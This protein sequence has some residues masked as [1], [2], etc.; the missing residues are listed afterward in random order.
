M[1]KPNDPTD[2][3]RSARVAVQ[4]EVQG[5]IVRLDELVTIREMSLEGMSIESSTGFAPGSTTDILLTL[6]DGASVEVCGTVVYSRPVDGAV[7]PAYVSGIQ[8]NDPD[9]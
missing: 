6:G 9:E 7:P 3:R 8:F 4:G 5:R 1:V 2:R